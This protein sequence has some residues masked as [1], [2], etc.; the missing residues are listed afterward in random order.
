MTIR[1]AP[2]GADLVLVRADVEPALARRL[3]VLGLRAGAHLTVLR[4]TVGGGRTIAVAGSR[5]ALDRGLADALLA[6][7]VPL[8]AP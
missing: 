4:R 8:A 1:A 6:E 5:I 3:G 7:P 2:I